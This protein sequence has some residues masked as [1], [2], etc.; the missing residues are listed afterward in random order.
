M[1]RIDE[2]Q[3]GNFSDRQIHSSDL[4]RGN[5]DKERQSKERTDVGSTKER[6]KRQTKSVRIDEMQWEYDIERQMQKSDVRKRK[7]E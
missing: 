2:I 6:Q 1:E 3:W 4:R 5:N 7:N